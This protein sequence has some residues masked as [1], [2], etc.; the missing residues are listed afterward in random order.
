MCN[1]KSFSSLVDR[2][3]AHD[4]RVSASHNYDLKAGEFFD[5]ELL[6]LMITEANDKYLQNK[7]VEAKKVYDE[8]KFVGAH[9]K[10]SKECK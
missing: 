6:E 9:I 5:S 8:I 10:E 3:N 1:V 7:K 2:Y 4:G